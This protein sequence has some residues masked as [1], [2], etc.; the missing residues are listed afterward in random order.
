MSAEKDGEGDVYLVVQP[1]NVRGDAVI[2]DVEEMVNKAPKA[3]FILLN[4]FFEDT[5][6]NQANSIIETDRQRKLLYSFVEVKYQK[7]FHTEVTSSNGITVR[8]FKQRR[9]SHSNQVYH[10]RPV[11]FVRRPSLEAEEIGLVLLLRKLSH[12]K[13]VLSGT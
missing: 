13:D 7:F 4:P 9:D 10:L 8:S 5:D 3:K 12:E 2:L 6:S 11:Y 1:K